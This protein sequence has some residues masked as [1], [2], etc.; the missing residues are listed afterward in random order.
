MITKL[1]RFI[2]RFMYPSSSFLR[3]SAILLAALA[4]PLSVHAADTQSFS[5]VGP[6]H[7]AFA[8]AEYLKAKNI[9]QGTD[10]K[11]NPDAKLT[12]AEA[13]K[14]FVAAIAQPGQLDKASNPGFTNIPAGAWYEKYVYLGAELGVID[15]PPKATTFDDKQFVTKAAFIKMLIGARQIDAMSSYGDIKLAL[16]PDEKD[17]ARWDYPYMRYALA[18]TITTVNKDGLLQPELQIT[19]AQMAIF[20]YRL[21]MYRAGR[22]TQAGLS[23]TEANIVA[24]LQMLDVKRIDDAKYASAR[25]RLTALGALQSKPNEP[26]VKGAVKTAEGFQTLILAYEAGMNGELDK[27]LTLAKDGWNLAEKAKQFSPSLTNI[28]VQMQ[29]IAK[30]MAD[31][32]R[33]VKAGGAAAM[34]Q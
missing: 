19:R 29:T 31:E 24:A 1:V 14:I 13:V 25:S 4:V 7:Q 11:F 5:D 27:V 26:I 3:R 34:Q 18:S 17:V 28:A 16:S 2:T 33:R 9:V 22:R 12:K 6:T 21:D 23:E 8:A 15:G 20:F 10:G 30:N 32:A